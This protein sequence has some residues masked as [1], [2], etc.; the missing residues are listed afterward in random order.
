M[1]APSVGAARAQLAAEVEAAHAGHDDVGDHDL[2]RVGLAFES[3]RLARAGG[4]AN[5]E[6]VAVEHLADESQQPLVVLDHEH[7]PRAAGG[8]RRGVRLLGLDRR[9]GRARQEDVEDR[10]LAGLGVDPHAAAALLDDPEHGREPE[11]GA[12][13]DGLRGE[14]R[15]EEPLAQAGIEARAGVG[16]RE[17]DGRP[18]GR[19]RQQ[20]SAVRPPVL[21]RE[22][23]DR[24]GSAEPGIASRA[25]TARFMI[26]CSSWLASARTG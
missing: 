2:D 23:L 3:Q 7:R 22:G 14:E 8:L 21:D 15:L 6:A 13:P 17:Q 5:G 16:D 12:L 10:A 24:E 20:A 4:G 11:S 19:A 9:A 26:T 18:L 1:K 25:L